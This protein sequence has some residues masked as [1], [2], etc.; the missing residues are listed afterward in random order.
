MVGDRGGLGKG[1]DSE[2]GTEGKE[3]EIL[4]RRIEET[5][6]KGEEKERRGGKNGGKRMRKESQR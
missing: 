3:A 4:E 6:R 1:K 2:T 5:E